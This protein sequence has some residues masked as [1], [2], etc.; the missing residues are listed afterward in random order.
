MPGKRTRLIG[1]NYDEEQQELV[2]PQGQRIALYD[3]LTL[4]ADHRDCR[5]D[6]TGPWTGWRM[7]GSRLIPPHLER[8]G[9]AL[10]PESARQFGRWIS[11]EAAAQTVPNTQLANHARLYLAYSSNL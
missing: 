9:S 3:V 2:S 11:G 8:K 10:K 7:R 1:W 6:F 4:L 5:I